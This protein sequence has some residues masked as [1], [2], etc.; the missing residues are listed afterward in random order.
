MVYLLVD[1][2][3]KIEAICSIRCKTV[4]TGACADEYSLPIRDPNFPSE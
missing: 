1:P 3:R 2:S 4:E